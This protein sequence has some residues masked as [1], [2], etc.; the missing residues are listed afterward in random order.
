VNVTAPPGNPYIGGRLGTVD[1]LFKVG[2]FVEKKYIVSIRKGA[3]MNQFLQGGL[4][5]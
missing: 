2:R 4:M 1:L 3:N 5:Y